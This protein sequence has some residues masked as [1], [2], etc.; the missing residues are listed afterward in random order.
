MG[1]VFASAPCPVTSD[2]WVD[3]EYKHLV[4]AA[5]PK[6]FAVKRDNNHRDGMSDV[7]MHPRAPV[8]TGCPAVAGHDGGH[9]P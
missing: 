1:E 4:V 9:R 7:N 2:Y 3:D 6:A 8:V 5:S